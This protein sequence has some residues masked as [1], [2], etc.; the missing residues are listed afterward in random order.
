MPLAGS[1]QKSG[2]NAKKALRTTE[3][4]RADHALKTIRKLRDLDQKQGSDSR[5]LPLYGNLRAYVENLPTTIV[6]NGLGQAMATELAAARMGEDD[7]STENHDLYGRIESLQSPAKGNRD[8][9][10]KA[11]EL[12]FCI[13][14]DWLQKSEVYSEDQDLM[15]AIVRGDQKKYVRAQYEALAYLEWLKKFSQA[16][17]RKGGKDVR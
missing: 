3:Q 17:L 5:K 12:L 9:D 14:Q 11:H 13:V 6:M 10:E 1:D 2:A 4:K 15:K 8:S 16:F 7:S